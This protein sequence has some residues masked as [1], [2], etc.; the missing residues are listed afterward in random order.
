MDTLN[1]ESILVVDDEAQLREGI[2]TYLNQ[3]CYEIQQASTGEDALTLLKETPFDIL[4]TDM[5]LPGVDGNT[6]LQE[7]L[8][9]Y[10]D[11][12]GIIITG[13]GTVESAVQAMK[14][15]AYD[16]IAKPFQLMEVSLLVRQA[17]ERRRLKLENAY[18]K[19]Q[20]KEKYR[21]ENI[22]G[23]SKPMQEIFQLV[24]TIATTNSTVLIIGETGT[25]KELIARAI[26]FNS[27]R[28]DQK[29][30]SINCGA[31]PETL[32]ESELFGHV[33]GAF[34]GAHQ[35][36]IGRFEQAHKG[37]IFLDEIATMSPAL[38]VK[39]LRVLQEREFERVGGMETIKVDVRIIAATSANL[40]EMV[41]RNEFRSDLYYRLNVIPIHLS[42]LRDRREDIPLL[43]KHFV[44]KYCQSSNMEIK[45]VAQEAM[46]MLMNYSWPGNI[47]QLENA[48]ERAVA[49]VG[50]RNVI[51][52]SDL[53]AEVQKT[54]ANL[55]LSE[56]YIPDEGVNFNTEVS[57]V[58]KELIMQSLRKSG[59]NKKQAAK[60]LNLKR[61]TLIEKLK[62]LNLMDHLNQEP[63]EKASK[64]SIR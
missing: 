39:L 32:L 24:E 56:I 48:I 33:K 1:S 43:T 42:A 41:E 34:T 21:F 59:G 47:R 11:L 45:T 61:T 49:L 9:I 8:S 12:I 38:Q 15:G 4:I 16:Y 10:P 58:E 55:F 28:K 30:V 5:K 23:N 62:R 35:T 40:K 20:L 29:I 2:A 26:H 53:P 52:P 63:S 13:Y 17:L 60:L 3:E 27:L 18:L 46:K 51:L 36:R 14:N 44:K 54:S 25:G 6:V 50:P 37:T 31:I 64:R 19:T 7:A 22:I 57:N